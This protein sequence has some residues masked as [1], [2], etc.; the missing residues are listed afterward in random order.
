MKSLKFARSWES[1]LVALLVFEILAIGIANPAFL[2]IEN[3][4]YSTSDFAHVILAALP[5]TLVMITGGIDISMASVM[6]LTSIV[7]GLLWKVVGMDI[8]TAMAI[9]LAVGTLA[10]AI[11]G[12]LVANTDIQPLVITLGTLFLYAGIATGAS[13][14]L[15][16]SSYEG[17]SGLPGKLY[18]PYP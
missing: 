2:N 14:S 16:A 6:G 13:A 15:V 7:L 12:F 11:N 8:F 18:R 17:I 5:L 10:G 1:A 3:L 9:A 4:L